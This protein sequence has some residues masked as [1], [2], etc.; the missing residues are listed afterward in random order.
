MTGHSSMDA[1]TFLD[2]V[3]RRPPL[4]LVAILIAILGAHVLSIALEFITRRRQKNS[5]MITLELMI[6]I[7]L[8]YIVI[9]LYVGRSLNPAEFKEWHSEPFW[10]AFLLIFFTL[11]S[12]FLY[13][14][15]RAITQ[16]EEHD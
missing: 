7:V 10:M 4:V 16:N 13:I 1:W 12:M 11:V 14:F 3:I 8:G 15:F 5:L 2:G 6:V 9:H